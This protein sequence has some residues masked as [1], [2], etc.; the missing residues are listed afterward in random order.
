M[1][2]CGKLCQ[3]TLMSV[4][5]SPSFY[6]R[7][8]G[9]ISKGGNMA[10]IFPIQ[11]L[12]YPPYRSLSKLLNKKGYLGYLPQCTPCLKASPRLSKTHLKSLDRFENTHWRKLKQMQPM[13]LCILPQVICKTHVPNLDPREPSLVKLL[14]RGLPQMSE[15]WKNQLHCSEAKFDKLG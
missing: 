10:K 6:Y 2:R 4:S 14:P 1:Q 15:K 5:R 8:G 7:G 13:W 11:R 3:L 12:G 9:G